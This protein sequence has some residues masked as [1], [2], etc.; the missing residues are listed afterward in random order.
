MP[1]SYSV[2][3]SVAP[4]TGAPFVASGTPV[5]CTLY[6]HDSGFSYEVIT[7]G[8][9]QGGY[10]PSTCTTVSALYIR[11]A[12]RAWDRQTIFWYNTTGSPNFYNEQTYSFSSH[13]SPSG[14]G[15]SGVVYSDRIA[16]HQRAKLAGDVAHYEWLSLQGILVPFSD[17]RVMDGYDGNVAAGNL[18]ADII[19]MMQCGGLRNGL[20]SY[21]G[22]LPNWRPDLVL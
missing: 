8:E 2:T 10:P 17:Y 22:P 9:S 16:A 3:G 7:Y 20:N 6:E 21:T 12:N 4:V 18:I 1:V 11:G 5:E 19:S 13:T 14:L 15:V